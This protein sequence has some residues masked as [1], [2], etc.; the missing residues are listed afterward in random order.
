MASSLGQ[1]WRYGGQNK[2]LFF[3]SLVL[4]LLVTERKHNNHGESWI[5][6]SLLSAMVV[7]VCRCVRASVCV[8]VS[9]AYEKNSK[10]L[11]DEEKE[12]MSK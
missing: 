3:C 7:Y 10:T 11:G 12:S 1:H 2:G 4:P 6:Y 8:C 9:Q 5:S